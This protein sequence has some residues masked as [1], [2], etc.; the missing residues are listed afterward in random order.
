MIDNLQQLAKFTLLTYV[1]SSML[2]MGISQRLGDVVAPLKNPRMVALALAVSFIAA[3]LLALLLSRVI[4][5]QPAHA[6]G[7]LLLA[8]AAGSPFIP[9]LADVAGGNLA[10]SVAL[11][12]LLIV[13]SIVFLPVV[14]PLMAPGSSAGPLKIA[15]PLILLMLLPLAVGFAMSAFW[16]TLSQLVVAFVRKL[17]NLS[18]L[19]FLLLLV[20]LNIQPILDTLGSF[21]IGAYV[22]F[23][24]IMV[25][26]GYIVGGR[27][28]A[29]RSVFAIASGQRNI[30]AALVVTVENFSDPRV[31]VMVL[32]SAVVGLFLMLA[33]ARLLRARM[34]RKS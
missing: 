30:S 2:V 29:S 26:M 24:F 31:M 10:Y 15:T 34:A 25:L 5:L 18:F 20:G 27:D 4:P 14:L 6:I 22:L 11:M 13:G 16:S 3:P 21:A 32:V 9:K 1:V 28:P 7:L 23:V 19:L 8:S 17:S 12:L 33:V